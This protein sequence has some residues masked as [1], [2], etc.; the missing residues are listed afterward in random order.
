MGVKGSEDLV[1]MVYEGLPVDVRESRHL[2]QEMTHGNHHSLNKH[3]EDVLN[4]AVE[5]TARG[6][7]TAFRADDICSSRWWGMVEEKTKLCIIHDL[8]FKG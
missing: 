7:A 6:R 1:R 5:E 2:R 4:K 3:E 8:T